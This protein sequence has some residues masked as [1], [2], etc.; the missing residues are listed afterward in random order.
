MSSIGPSGLFDARESTADDLLNVVITTLLNAGEPT[1]PTKGEA[2]EVFGARLELTDPRARLSRTESRGRL[3]SALGEL[4]WYLAGTSDAEF[5]TY[6]LSAY[7]ELAEGGVIHGGYGP[8]L[9]GLHGIDQVAYVCERLRSNAWS[10]KAVV[11]LF[12][13]TDVAEH[14]KDVPCTC[15]L[16][17]LLRRDRVHLVTYMRSN[18]AHRGL[19]HDLF[20]FTMLQELVAR[21][22]GADLGTYV[23][24]VG[25]LHLYLANVADAERYLNEG[26]QTPS[27]MPEMPDGD[28]W[29]AVTELLNV[30]RL[31]RVEGDPG[32]VAYSASPYWGDLQRLLAVFA[33]TRRGQRDAVEDL[34]QAMSTRVYDSLILDR[35]DR[36]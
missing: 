19:P 13:C 24:C 32:G 8:R 26:W 5:I 36:S 21:T 34:R 6:Y 14:H 23:H 25:S 17:F 18:D 16:Q 30:E 29:P 20:A 7:A 1:Y 3:F 35:R 11:Q 31:L 12:D 22:V 2:L 27:T 33:L 15:T 10:R 28:P 4:C 9:F